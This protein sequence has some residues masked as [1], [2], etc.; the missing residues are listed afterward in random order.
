MTDDTLV[1]DNP[2]AL[3]SR[4]AE[5]RAGGATP[6]MRDAAASL[7][8]PE[9][10]LIEARRATAAARR[11]RRPDAPD[12]FGAV[13]ARLPEV[14]EVMALTRNEACVHELTGRFN[15]PEIE[16][17]MGQVVGEIDLRLFLRGWAFGYMLDEETRSGP[18]RSLQFFDASGMAVHK[19]YAT[20]GTDADAFA[21]IVADFADDDAAPARFSPPA[22][23]AA[24]RPDAEIDVAGLRAA[25]EGL[26]HT[27]EFFALLRRFKVGRGQAMRLA[28]PALAQPAPAGAARDVLERAAAADLPVMVF[29]GNAHCV[30]IH[31]GPVRRIEVMGPWVNVLDPKFNLHLREDRIAAAWVARKPSVNGDIHSLELYDADGD[32]IAQVFGLRVAGGRELPEWRALVTGLA[33]AAPC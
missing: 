14:G 4:E 26:G 33:E 9:A 7:G 18:R 25:W 10:A 19:V 15:P 17:A 8:V 21:R 6:R 24:D 32:V 5:L 11:L 29:V 22:V 12:G 31:S 30:Q 1:I 27:H 2:E 20:Q 3:L 23:R 13:L 28:G 16:G